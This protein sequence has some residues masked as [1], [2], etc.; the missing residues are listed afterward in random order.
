M[1]DE[2]P[3]QGNYIPPYTAISLTKID[4]LQEKNSPCHTRLERLGDD[5]APPGPVDLE[6]TRH[7]SRFHGGNIDGGHGILELVHGERVVAEL[8]HDTAVVPQEGRHLFRPPQDPDDLV[9]H[10]SRK[11]V[12]D[13]SRMDADPLPGGFVEPGRHMGAD[14]E[15]LPQHPSSG[16]LR[17]PLESGVFIGLQKAN[18]N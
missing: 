8:R 17:N 13:A 10:V 9:E 18:S 7:R 1:I 12:V 6:P 15:H 3:Q 5:N 16:P 14:R 2:I 4:Q 11:V